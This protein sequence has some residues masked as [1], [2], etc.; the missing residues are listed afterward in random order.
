MANTMSSIGT[1]FY[2]QRKYAE[3][4][5]AFLKSTELNS[6]ADNIV[7]IAD[8][9]YMQGDYGEALAN[10]KKS[11]HGFYEQN[12]VAGV[13]SAL[14]GAAN[15]AYYQGS[16]DE[17]LDYFQKNVAVQESQHDQLGVATSLRGIGNVHR[18]RGDF[19]AA[20]ENYLRG[21]SLSEQIKAPTGTI[22]GSIGLVR[23]LQGENDQA[24]DYYRQSLAEFEAADNKIDKARALSLMGNAYYA[25]QNYESA[26]ES[27][28]SGLL[29]REAMDDKPGQADLLVGIG[30]V[31]L[32][33]RAYSEALDNYKRALA[34]FESVDHK[35]AAANVLTKLSETNLLQLDYLQALNFAEQA[36]LL[37]KQVQADEVLWY[38]RMLTGKAQR[39]LGRPALA[40]QSF[41][42]ACAIVESLRS[43]PASSEAGG[44]RSGVLPYLAAVDLLVEQN[45]SAEAFDYAE[46]AKVQ[47]LIELL[48]RGNAQ[49]VRSMSAAEQAEERKLA[50]DAVSLELQL[51]REALSRTSN[52]TRRTA[53][54][55]RLNQSRSNYATF[56]QRLYVTHPSLKVERG[57][58]SLKPEQLRTLVNDRR[59]ALLEYVVTE[60]NT[61]LFVLSA[62]ESSRKVNE[63]RTRAGTGIALNVYPLPITRE[64]LLQRTQSLDE[65]ILKRDESFHAPAR[66]LFDFLIKPAEQQLAGKTNLVVVPDG[67]LWRIPFATLQPADDRY[68]LDQACISYAPSLSALREMTRHGRPVSRTRSAALSAFADP[69][70]SRELQQR[71]ELT[72]KNVKVAPSPSAEAE[73][74]RLKSIYGPEGSRVFTGV[75]ATEERAKIE[76][77]QSSVLHFAVPAILDDI[78][79]MYSFVALNSTRGNKLN[80]GLLQTREIMNLQTPARLVVLSA[81]AARYDRMGT[82]GAAIGLAWSW[83]VAGSSTTVF[84]RWEVRSPST[85]QL[86][87]EFH[88]KTESVL[89]TSNLKAKALQQSALTLRHSK[90][91]QH[92]YYW[93]AF[94]LIGDGR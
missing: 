53:M 67:S 47:S 59:T 11:L 51:E 78:S 86:M 6:S 61:Y 38:A 14:G 58:L 56:R 16:Y 68:L 54:R 9:F 8:S 49:T 7:R 48:R 32:R 23:A 18:S 36:A 92:P 34:I 1:I 84:S 21:L 40:L 31:N 66:E 4:T 87:A 24:L 63:R 19:G 60:N 81:A 57:E 46:R 42:E 20:L 29:L 45:R 27:Y 52:E 35:Q 73:V 3:A 94:S 2:S 76:I 88:S 12:D 93:A 25:Q 37:A 91:Y 10:Y 44:E 22:L 39:S 89:R 30:T 55:N 33:K 85:T 65:A 69:Q 70:L 75:D 41:V 74:Q 15:S 71:V 72:Y 79:P 90:D 43:R 5:N 83:F 80:D 17:A 62:D 50:G 26:L 82:G 64:M 13:I 28:R 77:A